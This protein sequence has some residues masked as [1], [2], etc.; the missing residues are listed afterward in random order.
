MRSRLRRY[1][2][3]PLE[4]DSSTPFPAPA[5]RGKCVLVGLRKHRHGRIVNGWLILIGIVGATI[6]VAYALSRLPHS[7]LA[8]LPQSVQYDPYSATFLLAGI[9]LPLAF[10]YGR[11]A[12]VSLTEAR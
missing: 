9:T 12:R 8:P 10:A 1:E 4:P 7:N 6:A 5:R 11:R 3:I 2:T